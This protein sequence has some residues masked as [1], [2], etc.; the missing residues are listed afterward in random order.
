MES[1]AY[2]ERTLRLFYERFYPTYP[3]H[4]GI[5]LQSY[6]RRTAADVDRAGVR[7]SVK[8][9]TAYD[10]WLERNIKHATVV[11]AHQAEPVIG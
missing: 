5:V 2:A 6:L 11:V 4:V 8:R 10:L 3:E 9:G 7:I 1:S